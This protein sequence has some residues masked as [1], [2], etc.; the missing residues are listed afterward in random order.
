MTTDD[1]KRYCKEAGARHPAL[2]A[3]IQSLYEMAIS[4]IE[5]GGSESHECEVALEDLEQLE[6]KNSPNGLQCPRCDRW[7][8]SS[9]PFGGLYNTP[10]GKACSDKCRDRIN[11]RG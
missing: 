3:D 8:D 1:L 10:Y 7:F 9:P 2:Q 11:E 5:D 4:E 6:I